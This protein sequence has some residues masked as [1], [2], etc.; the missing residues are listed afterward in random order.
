[1]KA[2]QLTF[3]LLMLGGLIGLSA[4]LFAP[5]QQP[6][7]PNLAPEI[8]APLPAPAS[9]WRVFAETDD[10]EVF[11]FLVRGDEIENL[12]KRAQTLFPR[13]SFIGFSLVEAAP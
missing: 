13:E 4:P 6:E 9:I 12:P 7:E 5:P 11:T 1:M 8:E 10:G 3:V 2:P